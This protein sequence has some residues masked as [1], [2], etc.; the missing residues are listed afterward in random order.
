MSLAL[1]PTPRLSERT[2]LRLG[3]PALAE[4]VARVEA[5]LDQLGRELPGLGGRPLALGAGSNILALDG[6]L[7]V[8]LVRPANDAAPQ[9]ER[10]DAGALVRVGAGFGLPRL[11]GLCQRLA[12]PAWRASGIPGRVAGPWP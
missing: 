8:V 9:V 10:T 4:A 11:L 2:T 5:D 12:F 6:A 7:D 1:I 3:G